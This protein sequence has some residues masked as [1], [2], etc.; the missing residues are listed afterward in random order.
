MR[1]AAAPWRPCSIHLAHTLHLI[2]TEIEPQ[3]VCVRACVCDFVVYVFLCSTACPRLSRTPTLPADS[4][5]LST[6]VAMFL[7]FSPHLPTF[8][9]HDQVPPSCNLFQS[10][11]HPSFLCLC[12]CQPLIH[13]SLPQPHWRMP[14]DLDPVHPKGLHEYIIHHRQQTTPPTHTH[15]QLFLNV[16]V[17]KGQ[18]S[19]KYS[20]SNV[21]EIF[22]VR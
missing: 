10:P 11:S 7:S 15:T 18:T 20:H 16:C 21:R 1:G 14:S 6:Q 8:S 17:F 5:L 12:L 9:F 19:S 2:L 4:D 3:D 22:S 13:P